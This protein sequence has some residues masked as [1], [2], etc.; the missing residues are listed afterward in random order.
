MTPAKPLLPWP[1][2]LVV[3]AGPLGR[4]LEDEEQVDRGGG[5]GCPVLGQVSA[6]GG[7][8]YPVGRGAW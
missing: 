5:G 4:V 2:K 1:L 6:T 3:E 7:G 8:G